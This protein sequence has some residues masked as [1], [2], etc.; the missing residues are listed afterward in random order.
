MKGSG[1][2]RDGGHTTWNFYFSAKPQTFMSGQLQG[3]LAE[4]LGSQGQNYRVYFQSLV[5]AT[6]LTQSI[7]PELFVHSPIPFPL[8]VSWDPYLGHQCP[9]LQRCPKSETV[10]AEPCHEAFLLLH[11]VFS[12]VL[13]TILFRLGQARAS[14][15]TSQGNT[16]SFGFKA[17]WS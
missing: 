11:L 2:D 9:V 6:Q 17:L 8:S 5:S 10:P 14:A 4:N 7:F 15:H 13:N 3:E 12:S 16:G 1:K